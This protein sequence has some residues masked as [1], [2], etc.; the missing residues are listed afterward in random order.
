MF[1]KDSLTLKD[2]NKEI[3]SKLFELVEPT[4]NMLN[5]EV[6]ALKE[7]V[8]ELEKKY[9]E[10]TDEEIHKIWQECIQDGYTNM[11]TLNQSSLDAKEV[12][13]AFARSVIKASKVA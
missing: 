8:A 9:V 2:V 13:Y 11:L 3:I 4:L 12:M 5:Y 6:N 7:R 10:L 1:K